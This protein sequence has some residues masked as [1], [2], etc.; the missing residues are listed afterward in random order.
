MSADQNQLILPKTDIMLTSTNEVLQITAPLKKFGVSMFSYTRVYH[1]GSFIDVSDRSDMIDY[2]YYQTDIYK[3]YAPD[4]N[5]AAIGEGYVI[6][7]SAEIA[8]S[9][10]APVR[11]DVDLDNSLSIIKK[12]KK[13]YEVWN[14]ASRKNNHEIINFYINHLDFLD[15]FSIEFKDKMQ[16]LIKKYEKDR[17][18]RPDNLDDTNKQP[19][20]INKSFTRKPST[21]QLSKR[22]SDCL[23]LLTKGMSIKQI[24]SEL[25][26]S[27]R[28]VEHYLEAVRMKFK[29]GSKAELIAKLYNEQDAASSS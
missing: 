23:R 12:S 29:C 11:D 20:Y 3:H 25:S 17:I 1:D 28:T 4:A 2:F 27:A 5:P 10:L 6:L 21:Q 9:P 14:Y 8:N 7:T 22:Q 15:S 13:Y 16:H 24:A 19:L 18:W 26:L